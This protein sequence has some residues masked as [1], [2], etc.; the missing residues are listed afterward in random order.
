[1]KTVNDLT[2]KIMAYWEVCAYEKDSKADFA[3]NDLV[4]HFASSCGINQDK[5]NNRVDLT[6]NAL[7]NSQK[8]KLYKLMLDSGIKDW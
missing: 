3:I 8:R 2:G 5:L 6:V 7:T 1:M 4:N